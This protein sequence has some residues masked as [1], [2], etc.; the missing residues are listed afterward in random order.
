MKDIETA[1][2][3]SCVDYREQLGLDRSIIGNM[4]LC[5]LGGKYLVSIR[6]FNYRLDLK[7]KN[8]YRFYQR[9]FAG[10]D[11]FFAF[12]DYDFN[13]IKRVRC[14]APGIEMAEDIRL[15]NSSNGEIQASFTDVYHNP[16][17]R[18]G[19][20][21]MHMDDKQE[22]LRVTRSFRFGFSP[23]KNYIPIFGKEGMFIT[24]ILD[25]HL[26]TT[27]L[28]RPD[29][30]EKVACSG[31]VPY[32]GS[33]QAIPWN[34]G[35]VALVHRSMDRNYY[36]AFAFFGSGFRSVKFSEEFMCA[37]QVSFCCGMSIAGG[38]ATLPFCV[39]DRQTYVFRLPIEDFEKTCA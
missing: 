7:R 26:L 36:H 30:K 17:F 20:I 3:Y 32:R 39:E 15:V 14:R 6:K 9:F 29:E 24:D 10:R 21:N 22:E 1:Y 37:S 27:S 25:G 8:P 2:P 38:I 31:A 33:T 12:V 18:C 5:D 13:F 19:V 11:N 4:S 28:S 35:Y 23:E 16:H 34:D